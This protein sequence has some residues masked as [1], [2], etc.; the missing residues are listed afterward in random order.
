MIQQRLFPP[1]SCGSERRL[2]GHGLKLRLD[3]F[4]GSRGNNIGERF[5][6][7]LRYR[8]ETSIR[9]KTLTVRHLVRDCWSLGN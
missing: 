6:Q 3:N 2:N 4:S 1:C 8:R 7:L 9:S 5:K